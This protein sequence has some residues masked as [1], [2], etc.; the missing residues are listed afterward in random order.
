M[1]RK[2]LLAEGVPLCG[3]QALA[4]PTPTAPAAP[5]VSLPKERLL[6]SWLLVDIVV[7]VSVMGV[8]VCAP[9]GFYVSRTTGPTGRTSWI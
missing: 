7:L 8:S 6:N 9:M 2:G 3:E 4:A 1:I 5:A